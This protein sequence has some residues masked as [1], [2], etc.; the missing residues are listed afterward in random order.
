M[1]SQEPTTPAMTPHQI[2]LSNDP[3][4]TPA[5]ISSR[6]GAHG[7]TFH[8]SPLPPLSR[9]VVKPPCH[10]PAEMATCPRTMAQVLEKSDGKL[11]TSGNGCMRQDAPSVQ[12]YPRCRMLEQALQRIRAINLGR[13]AHS[14]QHSVANRTRSHTAL[15]QTLA[16]DFPA[17]GLVLQWMQHTHARTHTHTKQA[18]SVHRPSV[19]WPKPVCLEFS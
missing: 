2:A 10:L 12:P 11:A 8:S 9:T 1:T 5:P 19:P 16:V 15:E 4:R 3:S 14:V 18:E 17:R 7:S 6:Y 13:A